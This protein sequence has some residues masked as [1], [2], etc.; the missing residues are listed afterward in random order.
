MTEQ[1]SSVG[2]KELYTSHI[3]PYLED[4]SKYKKSGYTESEIASKLGVSYSA[5]N[6][7]K[8]KHEELTQALKVG[9]EELVVELENTLFRRALGFEHEEIRT[10]IEERSGRPSK[11]VEKHRKYYPPSDTAI[12]FALKKLKP[13]KYGDELRVNMEQ[14]VIIV[15]DMDGMLDE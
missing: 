13:E 10:V 14:Q 15:D 9:N 12:I 1:K 8:Q 11:R 7:Y 5:F 4:I 2:R 6:K 3:K